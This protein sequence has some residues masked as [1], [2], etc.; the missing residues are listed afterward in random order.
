[1]LLSR[2]SI[3][4]RKASMLRTTLGT[5]VLTATREVFPRKTAG[6]T[7]FLSTHD[8]ELALQI[9]DTV[10]LLTADNQLHVG[11]PRQL[12]ANGML[13]RFVAQKGIVFDTERLSVV[14]ESE[15]TC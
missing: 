14:V 2:F 13:G 8:L 1:M 11:T 5:V 6:K 4:E 9:A 12:A 10:W 3:S 7:V 15:P